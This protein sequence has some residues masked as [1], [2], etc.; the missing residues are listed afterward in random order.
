MNKANKFFFSALSVSLLLLSGCWSKK[1][2][3]SSATAVDT[4]ISESISAPQG[5]VLLSIKGNAV[6][7][8]PQFE[9]YFNRFLEA[10]PRMQ[11]IL[12]L[13][14]DADKNI[15][16][17]M[18]SEELLLNW[19]KEQKVDQ[20]EEFKN[21][22]QKTIDQVVRG[23]NVRLAAQ[24]FEKEHPVEMKDSEV[25][26]YYDDNKEVIP[27]I[28]IS[29]GGIKA[30]GVSFDKKEEAQAFLP[31]ASKA[32]DLKELAQAK[33]LQVKDFGLINKMS[34]GVEKELKDKIFAMKRFPSTE[35]VEVNKKYWV[36]QA[37][38]KEEPKYHEF[39]QIKDELSRL[40]KDEKTA[41]MFNKELDALKKAYGVEE[42]LAYFEKKADKK[43]DLNEILGQ[44]GEAA[45][46]VQPKS[47]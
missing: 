8:V 17:T 9:L 30:F 42:N 44:Q 5:E 1:E 29:R 20:R 33:K 36:I 4:N 7:T 28:L 2:E 47:A 39:D 40:V 38:S 34:P 14:P 35:L 3:S 31:E 12:S 15:F 16:M 10:N 11:Q 45:D 6:I 26:K 19:I 23:V 21:E 25:K 27:G 22:L 32:K 24:Y 43:P 41:E 46:F 37:Q 13:M 18:V